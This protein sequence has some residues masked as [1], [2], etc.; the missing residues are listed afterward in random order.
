MGFIGC[1]PIEE[2]AMKQEYLINEEFGKWMIGDVI[3]CE[4][5]VGDESYALLYFPA[6]GNNKACLGLG[7]KSRGWYWESM[8]SYSDVYLN[9]D[10]D[11]ED[12]EMFVEG[13][14]NHAPY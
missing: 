7:F 2:K 10:G 4:V 1:S 9:V 11:F 3:D 6:T 8:A 13:L 12:I 5:L 14:R